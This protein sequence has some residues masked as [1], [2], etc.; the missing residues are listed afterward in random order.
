[1]EEQT[2]LTTLLEKILAAFEGSTQSNSRSG[3]DGDEIDD[4]KIPKK[5]DNLIDIVQS[6]RREIVE[7]KA[8]QSSI[9]VTKSS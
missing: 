1:M 8:D 3:A 6:L 7:F 5:I 4:E 9:E 2:K